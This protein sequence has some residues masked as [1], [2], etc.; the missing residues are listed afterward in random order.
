M[1]IHVTISRLG[2]N[3]EESV[4][5]SWLKHD[6][7]QIKAGDAL[8]SL[9]SE[10]AAEDIECL[11]CG[12]LRIPSSSPKPGSPVKVG[13]VI[14]YLLQPGESESAKNPSQKTQLKT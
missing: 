1:A 11:D 9:E 8:F 12:I 4:F 7:D 14:G 13:D 6:G 3:I 2:W 10:K 5:V